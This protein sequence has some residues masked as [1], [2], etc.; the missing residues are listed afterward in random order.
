MNGSNHKE[1]AY[2]HI[3]LVGV[4]VTIDLQSQPALERGFPSQV[5]TQMRDTKSCRLRKPSLL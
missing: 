2:R 5:Y 3:V 1:R 4:A